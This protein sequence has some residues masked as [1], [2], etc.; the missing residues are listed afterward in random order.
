MYRPKF[1][2]AKYQRTKKADCWTKDENLNVQLVERAG[3]VPIQKRVSA[4][5][6]AG[7][8]LRHLRIINNPN[9]DEEVERFFRED[10]DPCEY[11][12][13][14]AELSEAS[15]RLAALKF[16]E[17]RE[18]DEPVYK[19]ELQSSEPKEVVNSNDKQE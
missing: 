2:N 6:G 19:Q 15:R 11:V 8:R 16:V 1:F 7:E 12:E 5:I 13:D 17:K 10:F 9:G 14:I 3:Y 18:K 4:L